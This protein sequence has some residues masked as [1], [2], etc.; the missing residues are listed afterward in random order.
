[1][2]IALWIAQILLAA[3]FLMGGLMKTTQ[4]AKVKS[5]MPW[6]KNASNGYVRF[7]GLSELLGAIGLIVPY[8]TG[9]ALV[10]TPIAAIGLGIIM[11]L[12]ISVHARQKENQAVAMNIVLLALAIFVAIGRM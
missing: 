12:A 9:I 2:N 3:M 4:V 10:L 6:A 5:T 8:A 7:I 1:M 11:V